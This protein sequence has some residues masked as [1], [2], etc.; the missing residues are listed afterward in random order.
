[1]ILPDQIQR[2]HD[3]RVCETDASP[4]RHKTDWLEQQL[5]QEKVPWPKPLITK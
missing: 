4:I 1:M 3:S 5:E 2:I